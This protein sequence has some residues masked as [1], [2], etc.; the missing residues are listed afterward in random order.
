M[1]Y[2]YIRSLTYKCSN[3]AQV[4]RS[5]WGLNIYYLDPECCENSREKYH[6]CK[7]A[8]ITGSQLK[9]VLVL[10]CSFTV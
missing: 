3:I 7:V 5:F 9:C 2:D 10:E 4:S 1:V 8:P 6:L